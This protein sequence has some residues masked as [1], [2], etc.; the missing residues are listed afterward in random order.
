MASG[1]SPHEGSWKVSYAP[2][3]DI[4]KGSAMFLD[5]TLNLWRSG[6]ISLQ[7]F[8]GKVIEGCYLKTE[9]VIDLDSALDFPTHRVHVMAMSCLPEVRSTPSSTAICSSGMDHKKWKITYSTLKDLDHGRMK[10]YDGT[11]ELVLKSN[12]LIL[13]NAKGAQIGFKL[14]DRRDN[15]SIGS[16]IN[17]H[18]HR[19][20]IGAKLLNGVPL[21]PSE[22]LPLVE[23]ESAT[24]FIEG[25]DPRK[26][27][28]DSPTDGEVFSSVFAS[29][30]LG[31]NFSHGKNFAKD[32]KLKFGCLVH[33]SMQSGSFTLVVSFGSSSFRLDEEY[34]SIALESVLGGYCGILRVF[35]I[36]E[37][38]FSFCVANKDVGFHVTKLRQFS[39]PQFKCYFHLWG[40]GGP[41]WQREFYFWQKE[42]QEEWTLISP[43]KRALH[44]GMAA[45]KAGQPKSIL[46]SL[47]KNVSKC[48]AFAK[49][50]SYSA[51]KGYQQ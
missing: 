12:R 48:L 45:M 8:H 10:A 41:N 30:N 18:L 23:S 44:L 9:E 22:S 6:W 29:L 4:G 31:L 1:L 35:N 19:V 33:P 42:L 26:G 15:F 51:C 37:R 36:V 2:L 13:Y 27:C 3:A 43:S 24:N 46:G 34:V 39:C 50:I 32:V 7:N 25:A 20:R 16:K 5:G 49:K 14:V 11:L 21:V 47:A 38:V 40:G 17:V 28:S